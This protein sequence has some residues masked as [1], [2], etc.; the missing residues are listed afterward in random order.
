MKQLPKATPGERADLV[1]CLLILLWQGYSAEGHFHGR[2]RASGL[3]EA[4]MNVL[5]PPRH[6]ARN[7]IEGK[8]LEL[9]KRAEEIYRLDM[10]AGIESWMSCSL[11]IND[12]TFM[13]KLRKEIESGFEWR[14]R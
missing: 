5:G 14:M 11:P 13:E 8:E 2:S 7:G 4:A 3:L 9:I 6:E 12:N 10:E 1:R